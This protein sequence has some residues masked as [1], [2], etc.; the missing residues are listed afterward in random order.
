MKLKL[1]YYILEKGVQP[2]KWWQLV[3]VSPLLSVVLYEL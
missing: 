1:L 2:V 3:H